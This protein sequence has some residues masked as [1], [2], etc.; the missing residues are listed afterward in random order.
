MAWR[1][2]LRGQN[3][4]RTRL[5][6]YFPGRRGDLPIVLRATSPA[7]S[8][9]EAEFPA[10]HRR[11]GRRDPFAELE[12][13]PPRRAGATPRRT[14]VA[15]AWTRRNRKHQCYAETWYFTSPVCTQPFRR[16]YRPAKPGCSAPPTPSGSPP[17]HV[18]LH[19]SAACRWPA[20]PAIAARLARAV[21]AVDPTEAREQYER[22]H[23]RSVIAYLNPD[24]TRHLPHRL[25]AQKPPPPA[26]RITT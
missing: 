19:S 1:K 25:P 21:I 7:T 20:P 5:T 23:E 26:E 12:T 18:D 4:P 2:Y 14:R 22:R 8:H 15:L 3:L 17:H 16:A 24:G 13:A 10:C 9:N 11:M 6:R